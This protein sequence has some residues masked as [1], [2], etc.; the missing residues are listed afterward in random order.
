MARVQDQEPRDVAV[1]YEVTAQT[2]FEAETQNGVWQYLSMIL[3]RKWLVLSMTLIGLCAGFALL[4]TE[5]PMYRA[6]ATIEL[7]GINDNFMGM[8]VVDPQAGTGNYSATALNI[9]T[10]VRILESNS[11]RE[12]VIGR[13][14][15]EMTPV[16]APRVTI[17]DK[18]RSR[19]G[20]AEQDPLAAMRAGISI[21]AYNMSA[22]VIPG[23]RLL[24]VSTE[25]TDP[26]IAA[27]YINTLS[28]EYMSQNMQF[29]SGS[30]QQTSQWLSSQL[31]ETKYKL[32]Q[33]EKKLQD[34]VRS[35][36]NIFIG[37][38]NTLDDTRLRQLQ[39]ELAGT[40]SERIARESLYRM[41][42]TS[43]P[44]SIPDIL[45][46][47]ALREFQTQLT[48]LDR[49]RAALLT[50]LTPAHYKVQRL[51]AQIA[52]I[53]ANQERERKN[54]LKRIQNE[55]EAS[56]RKEKSLAAAYAGQAGVIS[57]QA[58]KATEYMTLK[59]EV[60]L[61]RT[62]MT[63]LSQQ[64]N[65]AGF[66]A[67]VPSNNVRVV[68]PARPPGFPYM[69]DT[70]IRLLQ[71]AGGG[72]ALGIWL[73]LLLELRIKS[74]G[75]RKIQSPDHL[76]AIMKSTELGV[77]PAATFSLAPPNRWR[78]WNRTT[79]SAGNAKPIVE[80]A[81]WKEKPSLV[82][83]SFRAVLA[84]LTLVRSNG[85]TPKIVVVTSPGP[86]E[87]KTTFVS[88]IAIALNETGKTVLIV[89]GDLRR[90]RIHDL[91]GLDNTIG[92]Y[93]LIQQA[94]H[95][96]TISILD[97]IQ[98]TAVPGLFVLPSGKVGSIPANQ[99]FHS[100]F[101]GDLLNR[102]ELEFDTVIIDSPP[103]LQFPEARLLGREA[104]G[105]ILVVRSGVTDRDHALG[106]RQRLNEDR[107]P[108]LGTVLND[109]EPQEGTGSHLYHYYSY[110]TPPDGK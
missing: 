100:P 19:T 97:Y 96:D 56:V 47:P 25:S 67:A 49:E 92:V 82:A 18:L 88:N 91:Y 28:S 10:Q 37:D 39:A 65:Q 110:Y 5:K 101:L 98:Q 32:D 26:E 105:V 83:E 17:L 64:S 61:L 66:A 23:T 72:I 78:L 27:M 85:V 16:G 44:E 75:S 58:D 13:M 22:R 59:R 62:S 106:A 31:E 6:G 42:Q 55:Y 73:A 86:G 102:L 36:G 90:P 74:K 41:T 7:Q 84:S 54:I 3:R 35:S 20:L 104:D 2:E 50:T 63:T 71:G 33:A 80:H 40:Q 107:I 79:K 52:G 99:P 29:R 77:I 1:Q 108:I 81:S 12:Q 4:L 48:N 93:D 89:D 103:M 95:L 14:E 60:E 30:V 43:D 70:K 45:K 8:G 9:A 76:R 57:R 11:L 24:S 68:D 34:Y 38:Q 21:A 109:W 51:D 46:D 94:H 53:K 69:P 87:G 15:R